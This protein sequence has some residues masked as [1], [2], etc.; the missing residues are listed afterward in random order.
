MADS[1]RALLMLFDALVTHGVFTPAVAVTTLEHI[2]PHLDDDVAAEA[3]IDLLAQLVAARDEK[4]PSAA[5]TTA[6]RGG[7]PGMP[8]SDSR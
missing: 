4:R 1:Q 5:P 8:G 2:M 3:K 6:P 7:L